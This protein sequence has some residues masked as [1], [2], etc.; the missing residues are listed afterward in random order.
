M[1]AEPAGCVLSVNIGGL[2]LNSTK[3]YSQTAL[4]KPSRGP[5]SHRLPV[6][7]PE[8]ASKAC[9]CLVRRSSAHQRLL[10]LHLSFLLLLLLP[11]CMSR[12]AQGTTTSSPSLGMSLCPD[13]HCS[14]ELRLFPS[15]AS[16]SSDGR[17]VALHISIR[18]MKHYYGQFTMSYLRTSC[19]APVIWH[20]DPILAD[21]QRSPWVVSGNIRDIA[22]I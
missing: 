21:C 15:K 4:A 1:A 5:F 11:S 6:T 3:F 8:H 16:S 2:C 14:P 10:C 22:I 19:R 9:S 20:L 7:W 18:S 17:G 12:Q 13:F